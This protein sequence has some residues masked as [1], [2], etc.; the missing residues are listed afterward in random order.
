MDR[1]WAPWRMEFI[2]E[3]VKGSGNGEAPCILC[4]VLEAEDGPSNLILHRGRLAYIVLNKY[5]YSNGHLM[6]VPIRHVREFDALGAEEGAEIMALAQRCVA[7]L[8][9]KLGAHGFNV[10]MNLG[11]AAGAGIEGH[12]HLHVVPRWRD[13]HNFMA[14]IG[15][16]RVIPEH[17]EETYKTLSA[18]FS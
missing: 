5:P 7:A 4:G 9:E 15:D 12:L 6:V 14:T 13:D 8:R 17:I 11:E 10:G 1:L 16:V 18:S 3:R 2:L